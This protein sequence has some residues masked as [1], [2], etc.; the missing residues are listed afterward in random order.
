MSSSLCHARICRVDGP[1]ARALELGT[2]QLQPQLSLDIPTLIVHLR[3]D[4]DALTV[5]DYITYE[6]RDLT[7][8]VR[9]RQEVRKWELQERKTLLSRRSSGSIGGRH[10]LAANI[11]LVLIAIPL[12]SSLNIRTIER[13]LAL[14]HASGAT[15]VIIL[16][17]ADATPDLG[18]SA[19]S[20]AARNA[21]G[22]KILVTSTQS[23]EGITATADAVPIGSTAVVVGPSGAGK[24]TLINALLSEDRMDTGAARDSGY[25]RHTTTHRE[26]I[27]LPNGGWL[28]DSPG[29]REVGMTDVGHALAEVFDD[30]TSVAHECKFGDCTH[31]TE[32][33]CAVLQAVQ[34]GAITEE[35]LASYRLLEREQA[36]FARRQDARV[37]AEYGRTIRN[38]TRA[39]RK[40][41]KARGKAR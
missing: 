8:D 35:R 24:S 20:Q 9:G 27:R 22:I 26:L 16:T 3:R 11:D 36:W 4:A 41:Q 37:R 19:S 31:D 7:L 40:M 12:D 5:G 38:N 30:I 15:P 29:I 17:K 25:G 13:Y 23:G 34:F 21:P 39:Y 28:I 14:A 32:P 10:V 6:K 2:T 1:T 33:G 18:I